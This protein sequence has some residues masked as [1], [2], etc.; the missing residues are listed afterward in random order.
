M[1][2]AV[3]ITLP[4]YQLNK[5][6]GIFLPPGCCISVTAML[7]RPTHLSLT[8]QI[9]YAALRVLVCA[10]QGS[11]DIWDLHRESADRSSAD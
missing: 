9:V 6:T 5:L 10:S 3:Q 1:T 8:V 4:I 7:A 11:L 2:M